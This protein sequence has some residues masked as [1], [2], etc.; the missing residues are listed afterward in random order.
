[1]EEHKRQEKEELT[2]RFSF[3]KDYVQK[4]KMRDATYTN[5]QLTSSQTING[6]FI[7]ILNMQNI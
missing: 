5:G 3:C 1:M 2:T 6:Q 7:N 4:K